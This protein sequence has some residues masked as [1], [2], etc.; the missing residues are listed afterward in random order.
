MLAPHCGAMLLSSIYESR[1]MYVLDQPA[2][3]NAA[4]SVMT[5]LTPHAL[6][7]TLHG[8]EKA[9]G[10]D[11]S[12]EQRMGPRTLDLDI[13]LCEERVIETPELV[14]PHPRLLERAFVLVP[15]LELDPELRD[16]R[17]GRPL[18]IALE[19]LDAAAG[20][21]EGRGVYLSAAR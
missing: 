19:I 3:L 17:S 6:L 14:V 16:P 2:Y 8:I 12:L 11:R 13:L 4:G 1:P 21:P 7:E 20:G 18:S 5:E 10:R 15:L 9:L